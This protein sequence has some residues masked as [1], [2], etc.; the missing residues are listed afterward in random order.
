MQKF[1]TLFSGISIFLVLCG[2]AKEAEP[3]HS[4]NANLTG[5]WTIERIHS[6]QT[7][8]IFTNSYYN[9]HIE[10]DG[11]GVDI[12]SCKTRENERFNRSEHYLTNEKDEKLHIING[13]V[14]G[15]VDIDDIVQLS[16]T[17]KTDFLDAGTITLNSDQFG[18]V[19]AISGVCA[20]RIFKTSDI[21]GYYHF[22]FSLPFGDTYIEI[23]MLYNE[24]AASTLKKISNLNFY[25]PG[26]V[27][28]YS[29]YTATTLR[30][31]S[32]FVSV[33]DSTVNINFD[34]T[35]VLNSV[36]DGDNIT[37][38]IQVKY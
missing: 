18:A 9:V 16:K 10:D 21:D 11:E 12:I 7:T 34:I 17:T 29:S 4:L 36:F 3:D 37:G 30:V 38:N 24:N 14:I 28:Y 25:S 31:N 8:Q 20:Q 19:N 15:S 13:S 35:T 32:E 5:V 26:F 33:T 2:C 6:D 23:D 27:R 1:L 22:L